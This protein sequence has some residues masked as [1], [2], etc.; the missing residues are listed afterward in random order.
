MPNQIIANTEK[1]IEQET[2]EKNTEQEKTNSIV[3]EDITIKEETESKNNSEKITP[4]EEYLQISQTEEPKQTHTTALQV[5]LIIA[6]I[7]L[8]IFLVFFLTFTIVNTKSNKIISNIFIQ[9][10]DISNLTQEDAVKKMN[11]II[12]SQI[13]EEITLKHND[14]E[15]SI[16]TKELNIQF[17]TT[18]AVNDAY[19]VGRTGN[20]LQNDL[21][22]L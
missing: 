4:V 2:I 16:S 10:Y 8:A 20:L 5:I 18:T 15:T 14:Y 22:I 3:N 21:T 12:T 6:S 7:I 9:N 1:V 11:N 13:P 17:D 19:K